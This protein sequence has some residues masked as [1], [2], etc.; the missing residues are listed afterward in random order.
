[1]TTYIANTCDCSG[2]DLVINTNATNC[3][4]CRSNEHNEIKQKRIWNQ[5]R[6]QASLYT[7]NLASLNVAANTDNKNTIAVKHNSYDRYLARKKGGYLLTDENITNPKE[8]NKN[9][10]YGMISN[11]NRNCSI[12]S[13]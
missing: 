7:M 12:C 10:M 1:M 9:K 5:V 2:Q 6:A 11:V 3:K 8:G 4:N 13:N